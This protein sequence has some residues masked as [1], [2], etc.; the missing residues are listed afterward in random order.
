MKFS[1]LETNN[2]RTREG[3]KNKSGLF[4]SL[5][6]GIRGIGKIARLEGNPYGEQC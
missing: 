4:G 3:E 6:R 5:K 2:I 1:E